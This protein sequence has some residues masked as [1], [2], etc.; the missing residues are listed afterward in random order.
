VEFKKPTLLPNKLGLKAA[1]AG[2][3][4]SASPFTFQVSAAGRRGQEACQNGV[5]VHVKRSRMLLIC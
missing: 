4:A 2:Q 5:M 3:A 1:P